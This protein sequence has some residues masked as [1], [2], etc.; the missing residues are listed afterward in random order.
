MDG[1]QRG[2][3]VFEIMKSTARPN[4]L[5]VMTDQQRADAV[6]L[7]LDGWTPNLAAF[8]GQSVRFSDTYCPS[9]HCCPSR[10]T[11]FTGLYPSRHGVWNNVLNGQALTTDL[12]SGVQPWSRDL[13]AAGYDLHF[14]GKWHISAERRPRDFGWREHF[15]SAVGGQDYHGPR[16]SDY[17][18]GRRRSGA[19]QPR[20]PGQV[21]RPGYG[22]MA[23]YETLPEGSRMPHD[24]D[25]VEGALAA[26]K[27]SRDSDRPWMLYAG[28]FGPHDPYAI[29][30]EWLDRISES[31]TQLPLSYGDK[32]GDKPAIYRRLRE[33]VWDQFSPAEAIGAR[34]HYL[35][36]N[37]YADHQFGRLL[38]A[39]GESGRGQ[40][41]VV[42]FLSDHGDYAG[43]HG[44]F[45]KGIA[46]FNGAYQIPNFIRWPQVAA[47][48]GREC[49]ALVSLADFGPTF[50]E[51]AGPDVDATAFSGRSLVPLLQGQT[52][53]DW[54]TGL[55]TQCNGVELGYSQ[56]GFITHDWKYVFNGFDF[57]ELY[58]RRN[59]PDELTNL[60]ADPAHRDVVRTMC[61]HLWRFAHQEQ[62]E[63][64]NDYFTVALAP[65]GPAEAF[66]SVDP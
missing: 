21:F 23:L 64:I 24:E 60:A 46:S 31:A 43:E 56:R 17:A 20:K 26:L 52:P 65:F 54:R 22:A 41:T 47:E 16:W 63:I 37:A 2:R 15:V 50:L 19:D 34:R 29:T 57:D 12:K 59:D 61:G 28:L 32:M 55:G 35:A 51:M 13:A 6:S 53:S 8:A 27:A 25:A 30:R 36:Y 44:L 42:I 62:D 66:A 33:Q 58:D 10:A 1:C 49:E 3:G 11:F 9:P 4:F 18:P 40:N 39:L 14:S 38:E 48:A 5:V 45:C 7:A